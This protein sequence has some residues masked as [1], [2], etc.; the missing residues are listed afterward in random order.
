MATIFSDIVEI[1]LQ[2]SK[3]IFDNE[4][5]KMW[6]NQ[7]KLPMNQRLNSTMLQFIDRYF[8]LATEKIQCIYH[9]KMQR[10]NL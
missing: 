10:L 7:R 3:K 6:Q 4:M 1:K 5:A 8:A 9:Y 2:E